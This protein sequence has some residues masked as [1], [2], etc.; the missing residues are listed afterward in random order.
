MARGNKST[1][2]KPNPPGGLKITTTKSTTTRQQPST[3]NKK[4]KPR[5]NKGLKNEDSENYDIAQLQQV[6]KEK[7]GIRLPRPLAK[8][9][10]DIAK[11]RKFQTNQIQCATID[12]QCFQANIINTADVVNP[13]NSLMANIEAWMAMA[14]NNSQSSTPLIPSQL[15]AYLWLKCV[16]FFTRNGVWKQDLIQVGSP[17][18]LTA[19]D[20]ANI[21]PIPGSSLFPHSLLKWIHHH[22]P[23]KHKNGMEFKIRHYFPFPVSFTT[24]IGGDLI[25]RNNNNAAPWG[26]VTPSDLYATVSGNYFYTL[27]PAM[28]GATE[29]CSGLWNSVG[30]GQVQY[31]LNDLNSNAELDNQIQG[32]FKQVGG[33][34]QVDDL[35]PKGDNTYP[36]AP[37]ASAYCHYNDFTDARSWQV[38]GLNTNNYDANA[39]LWLNAGFP[40]TAVQQNNYPVNRSHGA[41]AMDNSRFIAKRTVA[42]LYS[43]QSVSL[44]HISYFTQLLTYATKWSDAPVG[45]IIRRHPRFYGIKSTAPQFEP[46][47]T[48]VLQTVVALIIQRIATAGGNTQTAPAFNSRSSV[49]QYRAALVQALTARLIRA[50]PLAMFRTGY[51]DL[52]SFGHVPSSWAQFSLPA[53]M[54]TALSMI[55]PIVTPN[56]QLIIYEYDARPL[57][58]T[59]YNGS[60]PTYVPTQVQN[61]PSWLGNGQGQVVVGQSLPEHC[62]RWYVDS[63]IP[64]VYVNNLNW[65]YT[66]F[67]QQ[68]QFN[69]AGQVY[70]QTFSRISVMASEA[71]FEYLDQGRLGGVG[72]QGI[73]PASIT[74]FPLS[75][76]SRI[77][78]MVSDGLSGTYQEIISD[79]E[80]QN[81]DNAQP[82]PLGIGHVALDIQVQTMYTPSAIIVD[83]GEGSSLDYKM[84]GQTFSICAYPKYQ[85]NLALVGAALFFGF[86]NY[87]GPQGQAGAS[88]LSK[89]SSFYAIGVAGNPALSTSLVQSIS[90]SQASTEW[91]GER[92]QH[93]ADAKK[94]GLDETWAEYTSNHT[95]FAPLW[96]QSVGNPSVVDVSAENMGK[97]VYKRR[98]RG[99]KVVE[100]KG[101]A[102]Y[103]AYPFQG[104]T[105]SVMVTDEGGFNFWGWLTHA[106]KVV[107]QAVGKAVPFIQAA[108]QVVEYVA[109]LI[110][111]KGGDAEYQN[112]KKLLM[113]LQ[114]KKTLIW[115]SPG[116]DVFVDGALL[117]HSSKSITVSGAELKRLIG[118]N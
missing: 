56:G 21:A 97:G 114:S 104:S 51:E 12:V 110:V 19:N 105:S 2:R 92:L 116:S 98:G 50:A 39:A 1:N 36:F 91:E 111:L 77:P 80:N 33:C 73:A 66:P 52:H 62:G 75:S 60:I 30:T 82:I 64:G 55:A 9:E 99:G 94:I 15:R 43:D 70:D 63:N 38:Y 25:P 17:N 44:S 24:N 16:G 23:Y 86:S 118:I 67:T 103:F 6:T 89:W 35:K 113:Y 101:Q 90:T 11:L 69:T 40:A 102:Y 32:W 74:G 96:Y 46:I 100:V 76:T 10:V 84:V 107:V 47:D 58:Q 14:I 18:T 93:L 29:T 42:G 37:D 68:V 81:R 27:F 8:R 59:Q 4:R 83:T 57:N 22:L 48:S 88:S 3:R 13:S 26:T 20:Y 28:V 34:V 109:P 117:Q 78:C 72:A 49:Q 115:H 85:L 108:I 53:I 95:M 79:F 54:Q 41:S 45:A 5:R 71:Q 87:T 61:I 112:Y 106:A 31:S 65:N 7:S